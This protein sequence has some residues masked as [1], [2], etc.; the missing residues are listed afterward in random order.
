MISIARL[1]SALLWGSGWNYFCGVR[2][3]C[4]YENWICASGGRNATGFPHWALVKKI[5]KKTS[6]NDNS[7]RTWMGARFCSGEEQDEATAS[8]SLSTVTESDHCLLLPL[9]GRS[10]WLVYR[11]QGFS[12]GWRSVIVLRSLLRTLPALLYQEI[13]KHLFA[14]SL[15]LLDA[16][17]VMSKYLWRW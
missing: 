12:D 10:S 13:L 4:F 14:S 2:A 8:S 16:R 7:G 6:G 15:L 17:A 11:I 3:L 9:F 5:K 1:R